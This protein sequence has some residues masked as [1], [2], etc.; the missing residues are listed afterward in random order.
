[1]RGL[2]GFGSL[3]IVIII[4]AYILLIQVEIFITG[5]S[6]R[7]PGVGVG[8][9]FNSQPD[10]IIGNIDKAEDVIQAIEMRSRLDEIFSQ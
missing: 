9:P 3:L 5:Q 7:I 8:F 6:Q 1:M 4:I 10:T 2:F